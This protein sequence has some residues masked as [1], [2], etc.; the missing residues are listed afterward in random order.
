M[1]SFGDELLCHRVLVP[2]CKGLE[3]QALRF[4]VNGAE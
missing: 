4:S 3:T 2:E 1:A